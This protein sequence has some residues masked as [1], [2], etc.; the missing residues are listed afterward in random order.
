MDIQVN[1]QETQKLKDLLAQL[2]STA[3]KGNGP[4]D[5]PRQVVVLSNASKLSSRFLAEYVNL[6]RASGQDDSATLDYLLKLD[7]LVE[8]N[9]IT[10]EFFEWMINEEQT[11]E[12]TIQLDDPVANPTDVAQS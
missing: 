9:N 4:A 2:Q 12:E 6:Q 1:A 11:P 10:D 5:K 3:P 8:E 7:R